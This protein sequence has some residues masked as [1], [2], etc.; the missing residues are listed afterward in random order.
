VATATAIPTVAS[1][2]RVDSPSLDNLLLRSRLYRLHHYQLLSN[3]TL[4][5]ASSRILNRRTASMKA[6]KRGSARLPTA[7]TRRVCLLLS[8]RRS[9]RP[10]FKYPSSQDRNRRSRSPQ[11]R[12]RH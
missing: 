2:Q 8:T 7:R 5:T 6:L 11:P 4:Q 1:L 9:T 10:P 12:R 3:P